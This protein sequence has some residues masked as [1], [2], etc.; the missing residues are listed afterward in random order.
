MV[1]SGASSS[2]M[3]SVNQTPP[4]PAREP[5]PPAAELAGGFPPAANAGV[6]PPGIT[7]ESSASNYIKNLYS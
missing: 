1:P 5:Q 7:G 4:L 3:S 6:V 2:E